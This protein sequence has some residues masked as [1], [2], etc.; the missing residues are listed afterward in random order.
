MGS[1]MRAALAALVA[2]LSPMLATG[3]GVAVLLVGADKRPGYDERMA[4]LHFTAM[5]DDVVVPLGADVF[6]TS[7]ACPS[8]DGLKTLANLAKSYFGSALAGVGAVAAARPSG[9]CAVF[10][11]GTNTKPWIQWYRLEKCWALMEAQEAKRGATYDVVVKLRSDATPR[12]WPARADAVADAAARRDVVHAA[13]DHV[14]Y[15][16]RKAMAVACHT[17]SAIGGVFT[18]GGAHA[19][20]RFLPISAPAL[21]DTLRSLDANAFSKR[22]WQS[23][24]KAGVLYFPVVLPGDAR[25]PAAMAANLDAAVAS[26]MTYVDA[27]T[28]RFDFGAMAEGG[29]KEVGR[30]VTEKDFLVWL[31]HNNVTICDL[32]GGETYLYKGRSIRRPTRPCGG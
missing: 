21:R 13:T 27:S 10:P 15:G 6:V 4:T 18:G 24:S 25:D 17:F 5:R 3:D 12:P 29:D 14:F 16:S 26:G 9:D 11:P 1:P 31:L 8:D 30:F 20:D 7:D 28:A 23:Y 19:R 22:T 32:D 2:A